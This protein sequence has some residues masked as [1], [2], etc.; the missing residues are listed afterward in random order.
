MSKK[1]SI[2]VIRENKITQSTSLCISEMSLEKSQEYLWELT[3]LEEL[4]IYDTDL[5]NI[6]NNIEKL[7]K[8]KRLTIT[9]S[10]EM[11]A[12][13]IFTRY[14][15]GIVL[16]ENIGNLLSLT[17]SIDSRVGCPQWRLSQ[18]FARAYRPDLVDRD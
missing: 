8:L 5:K 4:R 15:C 1:S 12:H 18:H 13:G 16:P 3:H 7:V 2:Q 11:V 17:R 10:T 6:S 14:A 9:T